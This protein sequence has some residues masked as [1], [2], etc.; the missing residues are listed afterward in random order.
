M[1]RNNAKG[2]YFYQPDYFHEIFARLS[3][4]ALLV[5][6]YIG[7]HIISSAIFLLGRKH[8]WY[9]YSGTMPEMRLNAA[10]NLLVDRAI[11]WRALH[12]YEYLVLG[13]GFTPG[14]GMFVN[15]R[16]YSHLVAP[17]YH[18]RKV[19]DIEALK[20]LEQAKAEYDKTLGRPTRTDYFPSYWLE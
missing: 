2:C 10:N 11:A 7:D 13:G 17:T 20:Q 4:R 8:V 6:S 12:G 3:G 15:K 18:F 16:G 19:H 1:A 5:E 14:D 9:Y